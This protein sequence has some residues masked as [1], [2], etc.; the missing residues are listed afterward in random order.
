MHRELENEKFAC[1]SVGDSIEI[2]K[3]Y[4]MQGIDFCPFVSTTLLFLQVLNSNV[5][6][7]AQQSLLLLK[8]SPRI[9]PKHLAASMSLIQLSLEQNLL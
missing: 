4:D 9:L 2:R 3:A 8:E 5:C 1:L 6:F 7:S